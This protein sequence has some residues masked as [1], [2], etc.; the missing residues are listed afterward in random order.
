MTVSLEQRARMYA[1][2]IILLFQKQGLS[3]ATVAQ[4]NR[5]ARHLSLGVKLVNP[6]ELDKAL[7]L[8]EAIALSANVDNV[9]AQRQAGLLL[10]QFQL[11]QAHWQSYTRADLPTT[12]AVGLAERRQPVEFGFEYPHALIA[13][14]SGSGKSETIKS[15]LL[16]LMGSYKPTELNVILIDQDGDYSDFTN[17][18]HLA[19]PVASTG[20]EIQTALLYVNRELAHRQANDIK[21]DKALVLVIDEAQDILADDSRLEIVRQVSQH[22]RKYQIHV[23]LGTQK[24]SHKDLPGIL[25]NLLNRF[26]GLVSDSRLSANLTGHAGLQAHKLT[27]KGDF[28]HVAGLDVQR[29]QVAQATRQDFE[30][31]DRCE[32]APVTIEENS[33]IELPTLLPD[34]PV[35]RPSLEVQP[36]LLAWYFLHHPGQITHALARE[37][38]ISRDNHVL[39]RDF[40]LE[41]IN[42]YKQLRRAQ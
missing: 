23:I 1:R 35:G 26:V 29:F 6:V 15:I 41:F 12:Q 21:N 36:A 27:G 9:L 2:I 25:D 19:M 8:D 24:P 28:I 17:A 42:A 5:G 14:T 4:A 31:L 20:E 16:S 7:K 33:L 34:R 40:C 10:Y 30:Q 13:G 11:A 32:V 38:G 18:A 22:G 3:G 37:N 39:H